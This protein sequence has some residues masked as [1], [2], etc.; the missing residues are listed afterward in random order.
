MNFFR[1][2][3]LLFIVFITGMAVLVIEVTATRILAPYFGNTLF[4][5]SSIIG[6]VLGALSLG[7]YLGGLLADKHPKLAVFFLLILSAGLFSLLIQFSANIFLPFLGGSLGMKAGPPIASFFL[8]FVPSLLLGMMSPFAIKLKAETLQGVGKTSGDV[9]FWSTLGSIAGSFLTGFFLIPHWGVSQILLATGLLLTVIGLGGIWLIKKD[10]PKKYLGIFLVFIFFFVF[11]NLSASPLPKG[12]VFQEDGLYSQ[13]KIEDTQWGGER[14]R[15]LR[16]DNWEEGAISLESDKL[17]FAY[18]RYYQLYKIIN[19]QAEKALFLGGGAY[20]NPRQILLEENNI[21]E[22]GVVEIEP[23]LYPLAKKYFQLPEDS[24]LLN[25]LTDGR[26]YL[27]EN[28][29]SYDLIFADVYSSLYSIP[30]HFTTQEFF[31]LA[32]SRLT[33][34]GV[35]L[36]NIIGRLEGKGSELLLSEIKTFNSVFEKCYLIPVYSS[37]QG[38][39]Q[40]YILF[41]LKNDA[42]SIDWDQKILED[43]EGAITY[44]SE[45]IILVEDLDL[46]SSLILTDNFAPIEYFTAK[47]F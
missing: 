41:G 8:F 32:E 42:S 27:K 45:R 36:M 14:I 7:Y 39:I 31:S 12:V 25:Y 30:I 20:S 44:L 38:E 37:D 46:R 26:R 18:T 15:L 13:I 43:E 1:K 11:S 29:K 33:E 19:P 16:L 6:V 17:P 9:F 35:F 3:F 28:D 34:D 24:R 23:S 47:L 10:F 21:Q 5:V 4:T 2:N 40:N 22:V